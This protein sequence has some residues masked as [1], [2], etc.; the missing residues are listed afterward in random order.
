M[1]K[2][3]WLS[4][5]GR[6]VWFFALG[7]SFSLHLIVLP[8]V[9]KFLEACP[10]CE[11]LSLELPPI[12]ARI[13]NPS[14]MGKQL[15]KRAEQ[16]EKKVKVVPQPGKKVEEKQEILPERSS[17]LQK[18]LNPA[19][20]T[21]SST[22]GGGAAQV[23]TK[24]TPGEG[25]FVVGGIPKPEPGA[26]GPGLGGSGTAPG[27]GGSGNEPGMPIS[28]PPSPPPPQKEVKE[29][30]PPPKQEPVVEKAKEEVVPPP[31]PS[32]P[33]PKKQI[34]PQE[35]A[36]FQ[37]IIYRRIEAAKDYPPEAKLRGI[38]GRVK[39][40]F[41]VRRDGSPANINVVSSSQQRILDD[42]AI[43]TVKKAG[44]YLPFPKSVEAD[45]LRVS[46]EI[47]YKLR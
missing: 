45:A 11:F 8:F 42:A 1:R 31:P 46:V 37:K 9:G 35:I 22:P 47:V 19:T 38:E 16:L 39:L 4:P 33:P 12:Y 14:Q 7:V 41:I 27:V 18:W 23:I 10:T 32:P 20:P 36:E 13:H 43:E 34:D 17:F 5:N 15:E 25:D 44:P 3:E 24:A 28:S 29:E 2:V 30:P 21:R 40:S 6:R 26:K